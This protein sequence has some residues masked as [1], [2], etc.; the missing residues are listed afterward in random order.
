MKRFK[1]ISIIGGIVF[2]LFVFIE[3]F[4]FLNTVPSDQKNEIIFSVPKGA[5]FRKIARKLKDEKLITSKLKFYILARLK[6]NLK[7]IKAGEYL[8]YSNMKP[9]DVL[10]LLVSGAT[11]LYRAT[12]P[13]GYNMYQIAQV[14]E[15][16]G[17]VSQKEFLET[18]TQGLLLEE[19]QIS[20][21]SCEGYLFPESYFFSKPVTAQTIIRTMVERFYQNY[22]SD[23][24]YKAKKLKLTKRKVVILASIIEKETSVPHERKL[25]SAVLHNRLKFNMKLQSDPTVIYGISNFSGNLTKSHLRIPTPYNTYTQKG[26]PFGPIA[27]PGLESLEAAVDPAKVEYLYF[28]SKNDGTHFFSKTYREHVN[29]VNRYQK[30][31]QP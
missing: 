20:G 24:Q 23:I 16:V 7:K 25:I 12:I 30:R 9:I 14:Y 28:V 26:L 27:N 29:A 17:L 15:A 18:C 5:P 31:R 11:Y 1:E 21:P 8:L 10:N 19:L 13:E 4:L 2:C 3:V 22:S 6:G